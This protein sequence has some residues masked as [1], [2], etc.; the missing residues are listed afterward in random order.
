MLGWTDSHDPCDRRNSSF[1]EDEEHVVPWRTDFWLF[2]G[3]NGDTTV[4]A[5]EPEIIDALAVVGVVS[6]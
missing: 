1:A 3:S 5:A 6:Y 2:G 4:V